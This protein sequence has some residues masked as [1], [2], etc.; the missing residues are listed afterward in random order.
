MRF[1]TYILASRRNGTLYVG[2]TNDLKRR[3]TEH[4]QHQVDG[5][6]KR[7]HVDL[8]VHWEE[9]PTFEDAVTREK[10][11]KTWDRKWKLELIERT[12]P[13]WE[14]LSRELR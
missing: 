10:R 9:Y 11:L 3:I 13:E 1:A 8:Q 7:Y 6:T 5:F 12:N 2:V 14:D 4:K